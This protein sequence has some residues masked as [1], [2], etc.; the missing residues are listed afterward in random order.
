VSHI[1]EREPLKEGSQRGDLFYLWHP[2]TETTF[3]GYGLTLADGRA[4]ELVGLLMVDRPQPVSVAWLEEVGRVFGGYQL[5]TMTATG[6]QG[7]ACRMQIEPESLPF[8]RHWPSEK[9]TAL[10]AALRPL[11][12]YPPQPVFRLRWDETTQTWA[13]RFALANEL[14]PELK[15]VFARTGYGCAAVETDTGI[16]HA[17]H[18]ADEDIAG[19]SGQPV[20]FQWQLIQMPTAPLI[21]LE[22]II[23]DD[24]VNPYRFESF[25]N[26]SEPD[27]LRIL[28]RLAN[29]AQLHLAFYGDDLTYRYTQSIHHAAQQTQQLAEIT[30]MALAYWHTLPPERQDFEEAKAAFMRSFF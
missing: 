5:L 8:L 14:P 2:G 26:V 3:S 21:R 12:D 23:V 27:Q 22:M 11:L 17:C 28:A 1:P 19:F 20:W 9:S 24:P 15:E 18:A 16:I 6:E 4:D 30:D 13:S 7:M 29:Q 25:L 10:Q